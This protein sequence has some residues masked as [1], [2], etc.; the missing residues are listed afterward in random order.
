M[1]TVSTTQMNKLYG[2]KQKKWMIKSN[3]SIDCTKIDNLINISRKYKY[4]YD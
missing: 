4:I 2:N 3:L 1:T